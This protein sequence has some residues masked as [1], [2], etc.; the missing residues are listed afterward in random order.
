MSEISEI[1]DV[2]G[3]QIAILT[4]HVL[5]CDVDVVFTMH[6]FT[7]PKGELGRNPTRFPFAG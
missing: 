7:G 4:G 6:T 5:V 3:L 1:S 2:G